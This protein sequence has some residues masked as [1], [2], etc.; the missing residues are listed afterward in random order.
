MAEDERPE[1]RVERATDPARYL[2]SDKLVW[3]DGPGTDPLELQVRGVPEDQR[4]AAEVVGSEVDP[5]TYAGI[6]GVRPMQ[7]S[8]PDGAGRVAPSP[9]PGSPGSASIPTTAAVGC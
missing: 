3:F 9:W 2:A 6:Y 4:F 7:L 8:V 1:I 5:A